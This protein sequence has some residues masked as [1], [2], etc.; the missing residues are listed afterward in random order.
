M[1]ITFPTN[2]AEGKPF[3]MPTIYY[4]KI[5]AEDL[6]PFYMPK[7]KHV[8]FIFLY[9][10]NTCYICLKFIIKLKIC[11]SLYLKMKLKFQIYTT[12]CLKYFRLLSISQSFMPCQHKPS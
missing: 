3:H 5:N 12:F 11:G 1:P 10:L 9:Y 8:F 6:M 2:N 7:F 4:L